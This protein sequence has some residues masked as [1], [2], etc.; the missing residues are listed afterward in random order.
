[1]IK[2]TLYFGNP[3]YLSL[4]NGQM[5]LRLPEVETN[6]TLSERF[7]REAERTFPIEDLRT[8]S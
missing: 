3:A 1:M 6:G 4:R 7:K 8:S 2:R 5:V